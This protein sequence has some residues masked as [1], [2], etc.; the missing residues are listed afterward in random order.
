MTPQ[1]V[2]ARI[3]LDRLAVVDSCL[4]DAR[5]LPLGDRGTFFADRR[6]IAAAESYLRRALEAL[7]D[8]GRHIL[9]KVY[10]MGAS[11][12]KEIARRLGDPEYAILYGRETSVFMI[13]AG[14][15]NR[16]VHYYHE[17]LAEELFE[18]CAGQL[19]DVEL[20][21]DAFRRWISE[22]P[23]KVDPTL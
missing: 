12:Y 22:N 14:Y 16:L 8:C 17:I 7:F 10:G 15:R 19:G 21:R 5:A 23:D 9:A 1:R 13:L 11:E 20:V 3:I 2:S 6:N 18:I 4:A